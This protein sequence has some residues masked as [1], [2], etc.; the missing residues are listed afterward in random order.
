MTTRIALAEAFAHVIEQQWSTDTP[1]QA[2]DMGAVVD[3][4]VTVRIFPAGRTETDEC[5]R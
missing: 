1:I 5:T 4:Q 3:H 2:C